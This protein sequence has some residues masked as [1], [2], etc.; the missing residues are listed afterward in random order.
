MRRVLA[1]VLVILVGSIS[2]ARAYQSIGSGGVTSCAE[3]TVFRRHP[4]GFAAIVAGTWVLGFLSGV[5]W[6]DVEGQGGELMNPL[7]GVQA[8]T[9]WAWI[10]RYCRANPSDTIA[11]AAGQ[12]A[13]DHPHYSN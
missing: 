4:D 7:N 8:D 2:I 1:G 3:W 9:V 12:F 13:L 10:D 11:W 5:G 6:A